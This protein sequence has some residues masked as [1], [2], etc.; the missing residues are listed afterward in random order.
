MTKKKVG[1]VTVG[2]T[3]NQ[4]RQFVR[5]TKGVFPISVLN[6]Y[7]VKKESKQ[8]EEEA[9]S[10]GI[11][12]LVTPPY[13]PESFMELF[14][15]NSIYPACVEQMAE[16]VVGNGYNLVLEEGMTENE[17]TKAEKEK[18][19]NL[20]EKA[21]PEDSMREVFN[22]ALVDYGKIGWFGIE[23]VKSK[24][25]NTKE[26]EIAELW[27]M[28][29]HTFRIHRKRKKFCQLRNADK[30]WFKR[31]GEEEDIS[32][33]TGEKMTA[34]ADVKK[35]AN[36]LIYYKRYYSKSSYYGIPNVI[37][38]VGSVVGLIGI[39]DF[40]LAFFENYGVP[41]A[42]I[43]LEGDWEDGAAKKIKD[44]LDNEVRGSENQH[45]T[46][47]F[48]IPEGA[49]FTYKPL[50]TEMKDS[51]FR[52]YQQ[53]LVDD[54]LIAYRMPPER[55]GIRVIG[56][57][58]G[59]VAVEATKVYVESVVEPLQTKMQNL[60]NNKI[61][62]EGLGIKHYTFEFVKLDV[63][64]Y[65]KET[66]RYMSLIDRGCITPNQVRN[67]LNLGAPYIG[68]EK[69]YI[70]NQLV[71]VGEEESIKKQDNFVDAIVDLTK[72]IHKI[73]GEGDEDE[74]Q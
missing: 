62:K 56:K 35:R 40:N 51:S 8:L 58:G 18:I 27:H 71:E 61:L 36:E 54:V 39:R 44:F 31:Y 16:D 21:N 41:V 23:V 1:R 66:E 50:A 65:D 11:K 46:M 57:L 14:E 48:E 49:S 38:A 22:K 10:F 3:N 28:P 42:L 2:V 29:A 13:R 30:V 17:E 74:I 6:K 52:I 70:S 60:I 64:D 20:V 5:T 7:E 68:G 69:Y 32:A 63:R 34:K 4:G 53:T 12:S 45:K 24:N 43:T 67:K 73:A 37:S 47:V 26:E 25:V 55:I 9:L 72:G 15:S 19:K 59:N 33:E